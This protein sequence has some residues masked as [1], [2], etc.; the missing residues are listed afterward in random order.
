MYNAVEYI[1]RFIARYGLRQAIRSIVRRVARN[2][3]LFYG[4]LLVALVLLCSVKAHAANYEYK[5]VFPTQTLM[6]EFCDDCWLELPPDFLETKMVLNVTTDDHARLFK[7]MQRSAAG[8][9]W[10]LTRQGNILKA[11]PLQNVGSLVY[12][13]CMDNRPHNVEK[14]LYAASVKAD[15]IQCA[16]RDSA[17]L[18]QQIVAD[19]LAARAEFVKDSLSKIPPLEFGHFELRY[20]AYSKSFTDKLGIE[21]NEILAE[22]NLHNRFRVFDSWRLFATE[23]ND[24]T[25]NERR[26]IFSLDTAINVDWGMEEQTMQKT[27]LDDGIVTQDYEWRKYGLIV[28]ISRDGRRV[29]MDYIFR[30][31]D[32]SVSVLQGSV[33]GN[34]TDTLRLFGDYMAKREINNGLPWLSK[35]P[36]LNWFVATQQTINDLKGFELYLVPI[37]RETKNEYGR[38]KENGQLYKP[39]RRE[40]TDST[41]VV[42]R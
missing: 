15:S 34:D 37:T 29:K 40:K 30:D 36:I 18:R 19:S 11:E 9:G 24:T 16:K 28:K 39:D 27:Y 35:I 1:V 22:G 10:N 20:Y 6:L 33:V 17:T 7:A 4:L 41:V 5:G 42:A 21:W 3:T 32:N 23:N 31:K 38:V 2:K 26:L 12:I 14:Y 8:Q 25:Y 13:S